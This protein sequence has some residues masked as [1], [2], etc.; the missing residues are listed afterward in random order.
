MAA[1]VGLRLAR[2]AVRDDVADTDADDEA[3]AAL[4]LIGGG[5]GGRRR[6]MMRLRF[7]RRRCSRRGRSSIQA[8][9]GKMNFNEIHFDR[10]HKC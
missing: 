9:E 4:V 5:G 6:R 1:G 7:W 8:G 10:D 2:R 3:E